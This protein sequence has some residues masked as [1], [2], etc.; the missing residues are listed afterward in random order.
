MRHP[1]AFYAEMMGDIMYYHQAMRQDD[2][3]KFTDAVIK[4]VNGHVD[5]GNWK[6]IKRNEVPDPEYILPSVWAMRRKRNL[7]TNEITKYKA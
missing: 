3:H 2:S 1:I 5:M 6:L 4:E 7:T